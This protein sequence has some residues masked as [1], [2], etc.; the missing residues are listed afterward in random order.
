MPIHCH[1]TDVLNSSYINVFSGVPLLQYKSLS[2]LRKY[3]SRMSVFT[4]FLLYI[5]HLQS[6]LHALFIPHK[7]PMK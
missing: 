7:S 1:N 3:V 5:M 4:E 2:Q 6:P